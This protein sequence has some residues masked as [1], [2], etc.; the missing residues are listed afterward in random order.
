MLRKV[1]LVNGSPRGELSCSKYLLDQLK[2]MIA[3]EDLV[4]EDLSVIECLNKETQA[5]T[6]EQLA[7]A[8]YI[9]MALPLYIDSIPSHL[10]DFMYQLERYFQANVRLEVRKQIRLY[11]IINNGFFEGSQTKNA[12]RIM[13]HFAAAVG[14]KWRFAV[15]IGAGEYVRDTQDEVPLQ[16]KAKRSIYKALLR[17]K[18]D[19]DSET[20]SYE[21]N[22]L[23]S[24]PYPKALFVFMGN[25]YW[26]KLGKQNG[27]RKQDLYARPFE[28]SK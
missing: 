13:Q 28:I 6:F 5:E 18:T 16:S 21:G 8:D 10:L 25:R 19:I 27:L 15:G 12:V 2:S 7:H 3:R 20:S 26:I 11:A 14:L 22:I 17:I 23:L 9:I 4:K 24:P 1:C